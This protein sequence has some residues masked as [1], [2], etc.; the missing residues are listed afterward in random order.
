MQRL[1]CDGNPSFKIPLIHRLL[2][3]HHLCNLGEK[4]FKDS[5]LSFAVS[6]CDE[7]QSQENIE[8]PYLLI[9]VFWKLLI[10][11]CST[12]KLQ[13]HI[14]AFFCLT[15]WMAGCTTFARLDGQLVV[16]WLSPLSF[17]SSNVFSFSFSVL[18]HKKTHFSSCFD[19][20]TS[21]TKIKTWIR[22]L[23]SLLGLV[24]IF[25]S[26]ASVNDK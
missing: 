26:N 15:I 3:A 24:R 18:L 23:H 19:A 5:S 13:L 7:N 22:D 21:T 6:W 11:D 4:P 8:K 17:P 12:L 1:R 20:S 14:S 16:G 10:I 9:D 25:E 2:N